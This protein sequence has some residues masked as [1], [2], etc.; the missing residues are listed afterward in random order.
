MYVFSLGIENE[1]ENERKKSKKE[2]MEK[3]R[4][5]KKNCAIYEIQKSTK[6][7]YNIKSCT[8]YYKYN[9]IRNETENYGYKTT[10]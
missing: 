9:Q 6:R 8:L 4:K 2:K 10:R 3:I 5:K 7:F 1:K